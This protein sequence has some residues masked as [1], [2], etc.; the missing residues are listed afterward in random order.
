MNTNPVVSS[1]QFVEA[2]TT[3]GD[4][5]EALRIARMAVESNLCACSHV[6]NVRSFYHWDG[7]VVA[8]TEFEVIFKTTMDS[9]TALKSMVDAEHS[10][11]LP[12]FCVTSTLLSS[13]DYLAWVETNSHRQ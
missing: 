10:Y 13:A 11:D 5:D 1:P 8:D 4:E 3:C 9:I 2:K 7:R 12:S 6:N